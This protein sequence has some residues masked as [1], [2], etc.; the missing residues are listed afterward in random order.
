MAGCWIL[1]SLFWTLAICYYSPLQTYVAECVGVHV[2]GYAIMMYGIGNS[3]GGFISGKILSLGIKTLLVLA[4]LALHLAT[5]IFLIF[6]ERE[7]ILPV[8][9]FVPLLWGLCDGSWITICSSKCV[10]KSK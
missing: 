9:L 5:M 2:V 3:L 8:I 7:P 6:W 1:S 10:T 4:T